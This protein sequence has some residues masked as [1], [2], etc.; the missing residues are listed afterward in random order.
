MTFRMNRRRAIAAG[1][2]V[3]AA[4]LALTGCSGASNT[5]GSSGALVTDKS[6]IKGSIS[7][8]TWWA[9]ADQKLVD[10]FSKEYPNVK[11]KL[12][13]TAIDSYPT[14]LQAEA[15]SGDLPDVFAVQGPPFESLTKAKQL[16][17]LKEA[18]GTQ[19]Y[20]Q[21]KTWGDS[22]NQSLLNGANSGLQK[23]ETKG[24][25]YGVPFNAISVASVY[26]KDIF[27]EVGIEPPTTFKGLLSN[28]K[29]LKAAGYI[30]M[31]M[32]GALW[33]GWWP[34]LAWDQTMR[35][36][37]V[38][39]F[40]VDNPDYIKGLQLVSDMAKAGCWSPSQISTD[41]AGETSLFL[42]KKTAQFVTV[43]ENFLQSI[44]AGA[45][46][47]LGSYTLP[48][49]DGKKPNRILGGGGANIIAVN[50]HSKNLS[51]AV[52][53]AKYLTSKGVETSLAAT[54]YTIPSIDVDLTAS[55]GTSGSALMAAYLTAAGNGFVDSSGYL[56]P[57]TAAGS[58]KFN[59]EILL[60]LILGKITA[61]E[62]AKQTAD[63]FQQ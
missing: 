14:K 32:T 11:V 44:A 2:V 31:S 9:Y 47:K 29:A 41:I 3:L 49:M 22:F 13:F 38:A 24:Q 43:P 34:Q 23:Y 27:D 37:K 42:Q 62:A 1:A 33:V 61:E 5:N 58:T 63:V 46:F 4:A 55:G 16:Y 17:D 12:K 25:V 8:S 48:A 52:A 15:S 19:A 36:D 59:T 60:N 51:A 18:L 28:C 26:N 57:M 54:Q 50:A 21:K 53:F 6:K 10:G 35:D 39:D 30:P 56:P 45:T 40:S 20:D 7:F